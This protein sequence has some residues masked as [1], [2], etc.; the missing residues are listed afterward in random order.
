VR[1]NALVSGRLKYAASI[2]MFFADRFSFSAFL[3]WQRFRQRREHAQ[4]P[5]QHPVTV[6]R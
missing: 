2:A 4:Q 5:R 6:H 1:S 3:I